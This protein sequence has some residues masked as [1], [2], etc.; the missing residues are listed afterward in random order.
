[1]PAVPTNSAFLTLAASQMRSPFKMPWPATSLV[2]SCTGVACTA[3]LL[4]GCGANKNHEE[5]ALVAGERDGCISCIDTCR[6]DPGSEPADCEGSEA[7]YEFLWVWDFNGE[8]NPVTG[9]EEEPRAWNMYT[10]N[11][12]STPFME[13]TGGWQP[14]TGLGERQYAP[15]ASP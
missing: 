7:G 10:Y 1:M 13:P 12:G 4:L 15:A 5:R 9:E 3:I 8:I 14:V 2:R 11:D 6:P